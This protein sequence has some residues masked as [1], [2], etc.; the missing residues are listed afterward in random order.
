LLGSCRT[1]DLPPIPPPAPPQIV[2]VPVLVPLAPELTVPCAK[3]G[4]GALETDVDL[5]IKAAR[6]QV[7]ADCNARKLEAIG[8]AEREGAQ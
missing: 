1:N 5:A 3:S 7:R 6:A 8:A 4:G 2:K